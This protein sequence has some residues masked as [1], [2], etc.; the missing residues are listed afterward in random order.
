[1][2]LVGKLCGAQ[3][4]CCGLPNISDRPLAQDR[5][6]DIFADF[7]YWYPSETVDWAF[8]IAPSGNFERSVYKT[9]SFDWS[10]GFRVGLGYNMLHDQWDTQA[11]Y[12]KFQTRTKD[13][14]SGLITSG[15]LAAR[16][17]LLEPFQTGKIT[18]NIHFNMF[19]WDLGRSFLVSEYLSFRPFI[20]AKA[21]WISQTMK[22]E[23]TIPNFAGLGFLYIGHE[24]AKNNFRG[25]GPK[26]GVNGKWILRCCDRNTFSLLGNFSAAYMWGNWTLRNRFIDVFATQTSI[27]MGSRN[28]GALMFQAMAGL[29]W[30]HNFEGDCSHFALKI[31][32]EIQDWLSQFQVFT[33]AAGTTNFDLVLQGLTVDLR[34][35]F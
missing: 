18:F 3:T 6:V 32:Y 1:M 9:I 28:F 7:L 12:T 11:Y 26:G 30:D 24:N 20:G 13:H 22:M 35:D 14:G 25:G 29:G 5:N 33:N 19:D 8:T 17:S 4:M 23:W 34:L 16:L 21:G 15:F 31:G 27:P 2:S 10:P